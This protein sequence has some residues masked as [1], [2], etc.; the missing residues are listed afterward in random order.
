MERD[1]RVWADGKLNR[2]QQCALAAE[3]ANHIL[4][5]IKHSRTS[6]L[7]EVIIVLYS[8]LVQPHLECCV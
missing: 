3:R 8:A 6:Q 7:K 5:C 2:S 4:E 1:L